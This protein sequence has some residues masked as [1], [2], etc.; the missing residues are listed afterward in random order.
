VALCLTAILAP[1]LQGLALEQVE[2]QACTVR[3]N[4]PRPI[5]IALPVALIFTTHSALQQTANSRPSLPCLLTTKVSHTWHLAARP[6]LPTVCL[7]VSLHTLLRV[8][9][10]LA[11]ATMARARHRNF[12]TTQPRA[13]TFVVLSTPVRGPSRQSL[14]QREHLVHHHHHH[15]ISPHPPNSK[16]RCTRHPPLR[17]SH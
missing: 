5:A 10:I 4:Y 14:A 7:H 12:R 17:S 13:Q 6:T 2:L 9:A 8:L 1:R 11:V 15:P 3:S 16:S